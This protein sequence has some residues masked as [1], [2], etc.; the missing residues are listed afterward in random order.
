MLHGNVM[1][2]KEVC[3]DRSIAMACNESE[4]TNPSSCV[5]SRYNF[6]S[7]L[8]LPA[9]S[10][11]DSSST[12]AASFAVGAMP[13][14]SSDLNSLSFCR[15]Y[16]SKNRFLSNLWFSVQSS[17]TWSKNSSITAKASSL[18]S[19]GS[20]SVAALVMFGTNLKIKQGLKVRK[21]TS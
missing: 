9:L 16:A 4:T 15:V 10:H 7:L 17:L 12:G 11:P 5:I 1:S 20:E 6:Q 14:S 2:M 3:Q 13:P 8:L 19:F 18:M 21:M